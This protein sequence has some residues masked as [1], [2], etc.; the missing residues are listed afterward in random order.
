MSAGA[1]CGEAPAAGTRTLWPGPC[2]ARSAAPNHIDSPNMLQLPA[3]A[4]AAASAGEA[5]GVMTL[6]RTS[7][8]SQPEPAS[9]RCSRAGRENPPSVRLQPIQTPAATISSPAPTVHTP[10]SVPIGMPSRAAASP[11][12]LRSASSTTF[13]SRHD[14]QA[15]APSPITV[16]RP[17]PMDNANGSGAPAAA[18]CDACVGRRE[19][20]L[21]PMSRAASNHAPT[22]V[23]ER[24]AGEQ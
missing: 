8:P 5:Y 24:D 12:G 2:A 19:G 11:R 3:Q 9:R 22:A 6:P 21:Q 23:S 1:A 13:M 7:A 14:A 4:R 17:W 15:L 20:P 10:G 16:G 18:A